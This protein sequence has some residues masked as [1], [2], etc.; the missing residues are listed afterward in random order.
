MQKRSIGLTILGWFEIVVGF[1]GVVFFGFFLFFSLAYVNVDDVNVRD[2]F[3]VFIV[4][5]PPVLFSLVSLFTG[6]GI[7]KLKKAAWR[8]NVFLH[9]GIYLYMLSGVLWYV[10]RWGFMVNGYLEVIIFIFWFF[11]LISSIL[12]LTRPKIREQFFG[13]QSEAMNKYSIGLIMLGWA[14]IVVGFLGG[15]FFIYYLLYFLSYVKSSYIPN[16]NFLIIAS[17]LPVAMLFLSLIL[18]GIGILKRKKWAWV[19]N[20]FVYPALHVYIY[21]ARFWLPELYWDTF[22]VYII[23]KVFVIWWLI[24]IYIIF[25]LTRPQVKA[26]FFEDSKRN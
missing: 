14:E 10:K 2:T 16:Q 22:L 24:P 13:K 9:P 19:M 7:L 6:I 21:I 23:D 15:G 20:V 5:L 26:C 4:Y 11:I 17:F 18:I 3:V 25:Y 12:Y 1:L 8:L